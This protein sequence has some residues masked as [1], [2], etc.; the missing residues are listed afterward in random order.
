MMKFARWRATKTET[1]TRVVVRV[2]GRRVRDRTGKVQREQEESI[3]RAVV[4]SSPPCSLA[5]DQYAEESV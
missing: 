3:A 5:L 4:V 2:C 1:M